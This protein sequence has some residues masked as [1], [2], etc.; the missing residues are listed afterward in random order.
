MGRLLKKQLHSY[1][2]LCHKDIRG[3][4]PR[5]ERHAIFRRAKNSNFL[6][7]S[8]RPNLA[9]SSL[10]Q[11]PSSSGLLRCL[12]VLQM[13]VQAIH[14]N[15]QLLTEV[16]VDAFSGTRLRLHAVLGH[17]GVRRVLGHLV[18]DS[19]RAVHHAA[20]QA[21]LKRQRDNRRWPDLETRTYV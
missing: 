5:G 4:R 3:C 7:N 15:R 8:K 20:L 14:Q 6:S 17:I 18:P 1:D 9:S 10:A 19:I 21:I 16:T 12:Q 13:A 11:C 2:C